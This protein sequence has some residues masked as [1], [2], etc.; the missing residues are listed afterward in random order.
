MK[1]SG[2]TELATSRDVVEMFGGYNHNLRISNS[3]FY[4]M[5]NLTSDEYPVLSTRGKRGIVKQLDSCNGIMAKGKLAYIEGKKLVYGEYVHELPQLTDGEK[6]LI[7]FGAYLVFALIEFV[8][9]RDLLAFLLF[10]R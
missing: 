1:L 3:E 9:N 10:F 4:N 5:A 7:S 2:L 6:Q 8:S